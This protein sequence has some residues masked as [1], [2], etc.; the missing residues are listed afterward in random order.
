MWQQAVHLKAPNL[1]HTRAHKY[2]QRKDSKP[3]KVPECL[4]PEI[5]WSTSSCWISFNFRTNTLF[6]VMFRH[7]CEVCVGQ[8]FQQRWIPVSVEM[9]CRQT[10]WVHLNYFGSDS[11]VSL[12][13]NSLTQ[14]SASVFN[15]S[16]W[17]L[18][19][20][21]WWDS[22]IWPATAWKV[23]ERFGNVF[24]QLTLSPIESS[25]SFEFET[26]SCWCFVLNKR[27]NIMMKVTC[28]SCTSL[29]LSCQML[30]DMNNILTWFMG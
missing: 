10:H 20:T 16:F 30:P 14:F 2:T 27:D 17:C 19:W 18:S 28:K 23:F 25:K 26:L 11:F 7:V 9:F 6:F 1:I 13:M 5:C 22:S 4:L 29:F 12:H 8:Q 24:Q 15:V 3:F 21:S